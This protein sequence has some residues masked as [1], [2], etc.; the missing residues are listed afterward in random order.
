[1][2]DIGAEETAMVQPNTRR[3][4]SSSHRPVCVYKWQPLRSPY[5]YIDRLL[6][7]HQCIIY[8]PL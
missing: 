1:M 5:T 6:F 3:A 7:W 2:A 8:Q 4:N